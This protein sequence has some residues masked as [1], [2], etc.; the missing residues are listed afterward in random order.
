MK[1]AQ[2]YNRARDRDSEPDFCT[3]RDLSID[4]PYTY[5]GNHPHRRPERDPI[6]IGPVFVGDA[7]G[8]KAVAAIP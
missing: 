7:G 4:D 2:G 1:V 5:F 6:P 3:I 8:A